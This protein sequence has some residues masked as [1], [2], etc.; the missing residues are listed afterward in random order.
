MFKTVAIDK[1]LPWMICRCAS[2]C[3]KNKKNYIHLK[4]VTVREFWFERTNS[5]ILLFLPYMILLNY[6]ERK[7]LSQR[8]KHFS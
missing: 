5:L 2:G 4:L 8:D 1:G 7:G 3:Y 6:Q